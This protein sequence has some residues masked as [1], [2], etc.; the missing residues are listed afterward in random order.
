VANASAWHNGR[1]NVQTG[2]GYGLRIDALFAANIFQQNWTNVV[3]Y[4]G[5]CQGPVVINLSNSA[6][7]G[8]CKELRHRGI[9]QWLHNSGNSQWIHG[10]P[11]RFTLVQ[12]GTSNIFD[13]V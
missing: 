7:S 1:P 8:N 9:G 6:V 13:V 2:A 11:P 10:N 3:L 4:F 12:R 5:G